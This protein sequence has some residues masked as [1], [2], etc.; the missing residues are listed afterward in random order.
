M[1][2][3]A[4]PKKN[5]RWAEVYE[6]A[7][8]EVSNA[9]VVLGRPVGFSCATRLHRAAVHEVASRRG[10]SRKKFTIWR[11]SKW[12]CRVHRTVV[13]DDYRCVG[14]WMHEQYPCDGDD[15]KRHATDK[16]VVFLLFVDPVP[17]LAL[18]TQ[19]PPDLV[20]LAAGYAQPPYG[21]WTT[22]Q[23]RRIGV[24]VWFDYYGGDDRWY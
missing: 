5:Q 10:L 21:T 1:S 23:L 14:N 18:A 15:W 11:H 13:A 19:L 7:K 3:D 17:L 20:S 24:S 2:D 8:K 16:Q 4:E 9:A 22:E 12:F 6:H